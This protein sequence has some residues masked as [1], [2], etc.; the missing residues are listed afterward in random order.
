MVKFD[1]A[2]FLPFAFKSLHGTPSICEVAVAEIESGG[3]S[4]TFREIDEN[5]GPNIR[6]AVEYAATAYW[7]E[8]LRRRGPE[9]IRWFTFT[10]EFGFEEI[11]FE[12]W[13]SVRGGGVFDKPVIE[14]METKQMYPV[15]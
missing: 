13:P 10:E 11:R 5:P 1:F 12:K 7:L 2:H 4:V 8:N 14:Y 6:Y 9:Q 3:V 15:H